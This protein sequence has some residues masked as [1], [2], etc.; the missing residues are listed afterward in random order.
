MIVSVLSIFLNAPSL[1]LI[2]YLLCSFNGS[3]DTTNE[4]ERVI[5]DLAC[6]RRSAS[7]FLFH[8]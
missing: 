4:R 3:F 6:G 8:Y 5:T 2:A 7:L 1:S